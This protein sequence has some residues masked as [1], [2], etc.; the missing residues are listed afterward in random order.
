[1]KQIL[2]FLVAG[3]TPKN[4][5]HIE[6]KDTKF[7]K[8]YK[9]KGRVKSV[10]ET[11]PCFAVMVEDLGVRGA[12]KCAMMDY[13][14]LSGEIGESTILSSSKTDP[15]KIKLWLSVGI[16]AL[17]AFAVGTSLGAKRK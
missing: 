10:L 17:A 13:E 12:Y 5:E 8:S 6:G 16:V 15:E 14:R 11:V 2:I 9:D 4:I 7:M 3:L 1:M